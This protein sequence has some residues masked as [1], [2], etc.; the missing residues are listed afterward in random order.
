MLTAYQKRE[1]VYQIV[2]FIFF[3]FLFLSQT[4]TNGL[5]YTT[6][7]VDV[8][9]IILFLYFQKLFINFFQIGDNVDPVPANNSDVAY[10]PQPVD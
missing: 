3:Y 9:L 5:F 1:T 7:F 8:L 4:S 10:L 6:H 2:L